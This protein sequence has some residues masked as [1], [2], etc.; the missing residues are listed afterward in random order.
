MP[1]LSRRRYSERPDCWH[2]YCGDVRVGTIARRT[3][4]PHDEDPWEWRCG[5]YPGMEPRQHHDG[6]AVDFASARADFEA[7]WREILP[8]LAD[9]DFDRWRYQRDATTW[10]YAMWDAG[11]KLPTQLPS[12]RSKCFCGAEL[13]I[14]GAPDHVRDAHMEMAR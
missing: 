9:A 7:A 8:T 3:G 10:K 12:G 6:T 1:E 2:V 4:S 14:V 11:M 5:F 13:T